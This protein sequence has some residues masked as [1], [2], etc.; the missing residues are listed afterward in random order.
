[1]ASSFSYAVFRYVKDAQRDL[2]I[3]VG[4]ALWS[5]GAGVAHTRF[6]Q[7]EEKVARISKTDD[8]PYIELVAEKLN[9][10]VDKGG[11][12]YQ[13]S[14]LSPNTDE[15]WRH[16]RNLLIHR[17]RISEPLSID[18]ENADAELE[19]LFSSIVRPNDSEDGRERIDSL[20]RKALGDAIADEFRRGY[21]DGYAGKPVQAMRVF[22]G[23]AGDVIV[24]AVDLSAKEAPE[25]ADEMVGKL[26]RARLNGNGMSQ[27]SRPL[28][29]I[30]GYLSSPG[31]LNGERYLKDW[32]EQGG[33]A[34]AF[35]L[36]LERHQLREAAEKALTEANSAALAN[37]ALPIKKSVGRHR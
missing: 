19:P 8:Y 36:N 17:I 27:K 20:L 3:P 29:A 23:T 25:Y 21:V 13:H 28:S 4:V 14:R 11:L 1:M 33:D 5:N 7:R 10:W 15:W 12:P 35:D 34:K 26:Q 31:G 37:S 16:V 24:D 2:T 30:V 22:C 32:I 6:I 9:R 18:C